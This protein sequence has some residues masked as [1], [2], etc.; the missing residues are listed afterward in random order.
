MRRGTNDLTNVCV[1]DSHILLSHF[2]QLNER[3]VFRL[4]KEPVGLKKV[5]PDRKIRKVKVVMGVSQREEERQLA[6]EDKKRSKSLLEKQK[7]RKQRQASSATLDKN[8]LEE[9]TRGE[10]DEYEQDFVQDDDEGATNSKKRGREPVQEDA[11]LRA[12]RGVT[13]KSAKQEVD[14]DIQIFDSDDEDLNS[15]ID[16]GEDEA[17]GVIGSDDDE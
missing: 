14:D 16:D 1:T 6:E 11:I 17:K 15:F 10:E 9:G 5:I 2:A 3:L 13:S 12:K 4:D 8:F 7:E